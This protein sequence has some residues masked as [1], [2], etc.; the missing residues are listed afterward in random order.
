MR[1]TPGFTV[2][3]LLI[4]VVLVAIMAG[5][6]V[7]RHWESR[8]V[9]HVTSIK[10]E[11]R[12]ALPRAEAHFME[13]GSYAGLVVN[14]QTPGVTL[15]V[16]EAGPTSYRLRGEHAQAVGAVC[17]VSGGALADGLADGGFAIGC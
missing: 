17:E 1:R 9:V 4:V 11:L 7:A 5:L 3:E 15:Q 12:N 14:A 13:H 10:W 16:L 8:R 6:A 2:V